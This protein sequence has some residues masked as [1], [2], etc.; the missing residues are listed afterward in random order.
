MHLPFEGPVLVVGS[1][2]LFKSFLAV[3]KLVTAFVG[4]WEE[5]S[6]AKKRVRV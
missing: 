6:I 1:F 4:A 3:K 5:H 2:V